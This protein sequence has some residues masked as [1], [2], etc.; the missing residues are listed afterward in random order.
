MALAHPRCICFISDNVLFCI[1]KQLFLSLQDGFHMKGD[2]R[3]EKSEEVI[4]LLG[5][6]D[7]LMVEQCPL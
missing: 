6:I 5:N 3:Q 7:G 1:C 4:A 2:D